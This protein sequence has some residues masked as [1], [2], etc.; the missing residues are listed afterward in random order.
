M[1]TKAVRKPRRLRYSRPVGLP[2]AAGRPRRRAGAPAMALSLLL[3]SGCA[4]IDEAM[5]GSLSPRVP[6]EPEVFGHSSLGKP[7]RGVVV[8]QG[9]ETYLLFGVIHGNEPMGAPLLERLLQRLEADA[10][11]LGNKRLVVIPVLNPDG[12]E[13]GSRTN[14][15]GV[16]LNRNFPASNW[17]ASPRHGDA[18]S[19]EPETRALLKVIRQ[20]RP[21]R[22]LSIHSPLRCVNYDGPAE[23]L[24]SVLA[25][26]TGYPLR[27]SIGYATPGS[28][29]SYAGEDLLIPTITL[30]LPPHGGEDDLWDEVGPALVELVRHRE[31]QVGS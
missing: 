31:T 20:F 30:E 25:R 15:R 3:A 21:A 19:S 24:A 10:G 26:A 7:I 28:L 13:R 6:L 16:D 22:I 29:G 23:E 11:L 4:G 17:R 14:A 1:K 18:P 9:P 2:C 8:G 27:S 12:L 5:L